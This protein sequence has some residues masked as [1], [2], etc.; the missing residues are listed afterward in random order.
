MHTTGRALAALVLVVGAAACTDDGE[1]PPA[2]AQTDHVALELSVGPGAGDLSTQARDELQND[3]GAV[4]TTYVVDAFLGDY[5]RDDFVEGLD[6]FTSGVADQAAADLNLVTGAGFGKDVQGV[7]ATR[8]SATI[9]S[10][11][12]TG[13]VVGV[14]ASVDLAFDVEAADGTTSELTRRGRLML[15]PDDGEWKIFGYDLTTEPG[16]DS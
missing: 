15:M 1:E 2:D 7:T 14:T 12:P 3:V 8:L 4:L 10:F 6:T 16:G 5:P 11:V 9:A 13:E